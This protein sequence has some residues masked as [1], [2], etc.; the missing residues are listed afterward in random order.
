MDLS[1]EAYPAGDSGVIREVVA[2]L[3][4]LP[5]LVRYHDDFDDKQRSIR[6]IA[7]CRKVGVHYAGRVTPLS[8]EYSSEHLAQLMKHV[9]VL[10]I[11][12]DVASVTALQYVSA[13]RNISPEYATR[14]LSAGPAGV[15]AVWASFME[16]DLPRHTYACAKAML[17][18]LSKHRLN[19]WS[20]DYLE[21]LTTLPLPFYDKYAVV[22][23]GGAFLSAEAEATIVRFLDEAACSLDG[24]EVDEVSLQDAAM[25][26][27]AY[28]FAMRPVQIASLTFRDIRIRA[29]PKG[30][31]PSVHLTFRMVKQRNNVVAKAL[32]RRV[33]F[34]WGSIFVSLSMLAQSNGAEAADRAFG[35]ES[36][37]EA[38]LRISA[39][40]RRLTGGDESTYNLRHTA[41][42]RLVDAG[43]SHEELAEF[44]GHSNSSTA[45]VYYE[46]SVNQAERVNRALGISEIYQRVASIAHHRY[47]TPEELARLKG[48][49]QIAG[50][51]HGVA[52]AGI[53]GCTSGQ[54][55]CPFNPIM[56]CYGCRRFMPVQDVEMHSRVLDDLRGIA[57]FF[58]DSSR[59][60]SVSPTYLQLQRTISD[61]K[62]VVA[63]L[64]DL[65]K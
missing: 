35:V 41:A 53:G 40:L 54:P 10:L 42:Q 3:P 64:E 5:S 8:F 43:A 32:L 20:E 33:K 12:E 16:L 28:Q 23:S 38:G 25:L 44:L 31:T 39:L 22:R 58:L 63:E 7:S 65:V 37:Y 62:A 36:S 61:V 55:A 45:L 56:S 17:H 6:D 4:A 27:C 19:G 15:A 59:S 57:R 52:I 2:A 46:T 13:G 21:L 18:L 11:G 47:I 24:G 50:V 1:K 51:P 29:D 34:E 14:L 30:Q 49:Q 9:F 48:D 26:L 60:D